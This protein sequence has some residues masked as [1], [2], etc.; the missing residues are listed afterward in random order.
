M[1]PD[2]LTLPDH[3][4]ATENFFGLLH[5]EL[6]EP[7]RHFSVL[8]GTIEQLRKSGGMTTCPTVETLFQEVATLARETSESVRRVTDLAELVGEAPMVAED[9]ILI[10]DLLRTATSHAREALLARGL[11]VDLEIF[12]SHPSPIHGSRRWLLL[13]F[14]ELFGRLMEG[15]PANAHLMFGLRQM[16]AHQLLGATTGLAPPA[17]RQQILLRQVDVADEHRATGAYGKQLSVTLV[18]RIIEAHHGH[19]DTHTDESGALL[20]FAMS[21]PTDGRR[22]V[23]PAPDCTQCLA[24]RQAER[25]AEELGEL[26]AQLRTRHQK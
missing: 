21:L 14:D 12:A 22:P 4:V 19:L 6:V 10:E 24:R 11:G 18:R 3:S 9:E 13:A 15:A 2:P 17:G 23:L 16:G 7:L 5:R 1:I 8:A 25:Y 20:S 26:I